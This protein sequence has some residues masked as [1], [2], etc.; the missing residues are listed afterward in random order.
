V[1]KCYIGRDRKTLFINL[2]IAIKEKEYH[3]WTKE[4]IN[5]QLREGS[6]FYL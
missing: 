4:E 3:K 5:Q 6:E 2:Q 1:Y